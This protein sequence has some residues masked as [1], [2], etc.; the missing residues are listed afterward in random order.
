L[1]PD[2]KG[3]HSLKVFENRILRKISVRKMNEVVGGW[4]NCILGRFVTVTLRQIY[5]ERSSKRDKMGTVCSTH[6]EKRNVY[7]N[8][9]GNPEGKGPLGMPGRR[10]KYD[11]KRILRK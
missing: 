9:V 3:T 11:I 6:W 2:N 10:Q 1:V 7:R 4:R 5:L 8:L